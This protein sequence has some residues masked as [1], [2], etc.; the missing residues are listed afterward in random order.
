[1]W[2]IVKANFVM[3]SK[4]TTLDSVN[5]NNIHLIVSILVNFY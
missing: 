3:I 4:E 5:I 1:M 2:K